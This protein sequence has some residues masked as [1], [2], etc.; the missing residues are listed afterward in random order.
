[1]RRFIFDEGGTASTSS[2]LLK[3]QRLLD[4]ACEFASEIAQRGGTVLFVG[5]KKQARDAVRDVAQAA[6]MPYVNHR[7]LGGLLTNFQT[8]SER[9]KRLH[10]LER[11]EVEGQLACCCPRANVCPRRPTS[12]SCA[13]TSA[14]VKDI[15]GARRA[16][17]S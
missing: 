6:G 2:I 4:Q 14:S 3:T 13:R 5:T 1:M 12:R 15:A 17:S 11:Y 10:D 7:W 9:I 8:I 16:R